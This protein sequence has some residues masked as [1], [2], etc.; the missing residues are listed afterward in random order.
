MTD[1]RS[2]PTTPAPPTTPLAVPGDAPLAPPRG[3]RCFGDGDTLY[4]EYHDSEWAVPVHGDQALFERIALEG[5]QSGLS[6]ITVLR[7]RPAFRAAFAGFDPEV[8][9]TFGDDDVA[10]L[11]AD[12]GIIRN[13][14]KIE[15]TVSNAR[16]LLALHE[17]GRTLDEVFWSFAPPP[18]A[19]RPRSWADVPGRTTESLALSKALK[20]DGFR[21]VGPT[22]AYAAMQACGVVDDH[23]ATCPVV[24]AP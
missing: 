10:R 12:A 17:Q 21:F 7:K 15:A 11:L 13:R 22:T 23:L 20:K 16:A 14:Q 8:V 9:A 6:W 1:A 24:L 4:E 5:F 2:E 18:R 19:E 3:A